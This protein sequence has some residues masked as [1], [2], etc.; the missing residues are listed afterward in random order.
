MS[1]KNPQVP[2]HPAQVIRQ[3]T[4]LG[5][6]SLTTEP[7][8]T[9]DVDPEG[10][11]V[12]IRL[13][14]TKREPLRLISP[15][16]TEVPKHLQHPKE[17]AAF[18]RA[19]KENEAFGG[20]TVAPG[21][22]LY[23]QYHAGSE[24]VQ[25]VR[26]HKDDARF[27]GYWEALRHGGITP[28]KIPDALI[29]DINLRRLVRGNYSQ[30]YGYLELVIPDERQRANFVK[31]G[32][33]IPELEAEEARREEKARA[34]VT[35]EEGKWLADLMGSD[36][37]RRD[38]AKVIKKYLS[39]HGVKISVTTPSYSMAS[40]VQIS[41][42]D[43]SKFGILADRINALLPGAGVQDYQ[44]SDD[45]KPQNKED[46]SDSQ[47]DYYH[48][49]GVRIPPRLEA[50]VRKIIAGLKKENPHQESSEV[51]SLV[52]DNSVFSVAKAK[53]WAKKHNFLYGSVDEK[54]NSIRLRQRDPS[55]FLPSHFG[56]IPITDG[57]MAVV[58]VPR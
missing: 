55:D 12:H 34:A 30:T 32:Q 36:A 38:Y 45:L 57:V 49:G 53:A 20:L 16:P 11:D 1:R 15:E 52:F 48:P 10:D 54:A 17:A 4:E 35:Q 5:A 13:S 33:K 39:N 41:T 25:L 47:S 9:V 24:A 27:P 3:K 26:F 44:S 8:V 56:T 21:T 40:G 50:E 31:A 28:F 14:R 19:E 7:G 18:Y 22:W 51:Q 58:G 6:F 2:G 23:G 29:Q 43:G 42:L 46:R 37:N